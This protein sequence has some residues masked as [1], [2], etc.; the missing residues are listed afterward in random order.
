MIRPSSTNVGVCCYQVRCYLINR[1]GAVIAIPGL[2]F[3]CCS[4]NF[5]SKTNLEPRAESA[6]LEP[7]MRFLVF[8]YDVCVRARAPTTCDKSLSLLNKSPSLLDKPPFALDLRASF[9]L[10]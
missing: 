7:E 5:E 4:A 9:S 2:K 8:Y 6:I 1:A 10:L 3:S